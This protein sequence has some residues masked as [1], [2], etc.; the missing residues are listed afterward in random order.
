MTPSLVKSNFAR[1]LHTM[2]HL[3]E[4][5]FHDSLMDYVLSLYALTVKLVEWNSANA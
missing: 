2:E 5:V 4:R 1:R 3:L